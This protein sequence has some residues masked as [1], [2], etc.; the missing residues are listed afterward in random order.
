[1]LVL[2]R[3]V[4]Q[5]IPIGD[6]IVITIVQIDSNQVRVGIAAPKE[7]PVHRGEIKQR[8]KNVKK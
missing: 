8:I 7:V 1:M 2:T 6:V 5:T 4:D 3:S